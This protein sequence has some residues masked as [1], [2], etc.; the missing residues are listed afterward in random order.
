[1]K[2]CTKPIP[3]SSFHLF[4]DSSP[5]FGIGVVIGDRYDRFKL[6]EDWRTRDNSARDPT[7]ESQRIITRDNNWAEFA[8]VYLLLFFF[9]KL[10]PDTSDVHLEVNSDSM[11]VV[12]A[13]KARRSRNDD[14]NEILGA[15]L[16]LLVE[17][18]SF[19]TVSYIPSLQNPADPP[20][21]GQSLPNHTRTQFP[22]FP[23]LLRGLMIR[24]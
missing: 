19:I 14:Q 4:A 15:M 24:E 1:M 23:H 9:F 22:S 11:A 10:H 6:A 3:N 18:Q 5:V 7:W 20:S 8:A 12:D 17:R 16:R 2:L 13:W 21:R